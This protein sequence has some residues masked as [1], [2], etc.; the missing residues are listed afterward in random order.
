MPGDEFEQLI[1]RLRT[2]DEAAAAELVRG[3]ESEVRR[4]VRFRLTTP[5]IRRFIDSLDV[6]QSVLGRFFV[7][8]REGKLEV[9]TPGQLRN[10]LLTMARNKLYDQVR[11]E[12]T[13][14]RDAT[15]VEGNGDAEFVDHGDSVSE[16]VADIEFVN[17]FRARLSSE[18]RYLVDQRMKALPD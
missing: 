3:Y 5:A 4:F 16:K 11:K 1:A 17:A 15:R 14:K 10:L 18:E 7:E 9:N 2:G 12:L 6:S 8:L 13:E